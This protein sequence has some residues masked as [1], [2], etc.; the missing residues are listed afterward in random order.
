VLRADEAIA[1]ADAGA[2]GVI[3]SNHGGRNLESSA[4]PLEVLP[5]IVDAV[6]QRMSILID[7]GF[8]SGTDIVKALALGAKAVLLGRAGGYAVASGGEAAVNR[9]LD[10]MRDE[11]DRTLGYLGCT[12]IDQLSRDLLLVEHTRP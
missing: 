2:D 4:A 7:S 8:R 11:V 3:L 12:A 5:E 1:I 9:L 10:M 6:G